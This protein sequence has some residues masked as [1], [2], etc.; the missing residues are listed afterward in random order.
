MATQRDITSRKQADDKI[1]YLARYDGLTGLVNRGVFVE[2][3]KL[4]I[5]RSQRGAK[6]LAVLYLDLDHFKDVN[7]TLGHPVGDLLLQAVAERLRANVRVIDIVARFGGDEF[8][9]ILTD[10]QEPLTRRSS[11][12]GYWTPSANLS[13]SKRRPP[14]LPRT[15]F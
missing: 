5:A 13:R 10:I 15:R 11:L 12:T 6:G 4:A 7:D 9:I 3:L 1:A 8:A 14:P 2:A